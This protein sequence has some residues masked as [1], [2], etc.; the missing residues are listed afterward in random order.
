MGVLSE[1][2]QEMA[3]AMARMQKRPM[4]ETLPVLLVQERVEPPSSLQ[5]MT[6]LAGQFEV[7]EEQPIEQFYVLTWLVP[8]RQFMMPLVDG[9]Y[10]FPPLGMLGGLVIQSHGL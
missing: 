7:L 10:A 6:P 5:F 2:V 3:L 4:D 9:Q 1:R 8:V